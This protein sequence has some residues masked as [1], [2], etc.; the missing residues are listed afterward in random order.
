MNL[1]INYEKGGSERRRNEVSEIEARVMS[2]KMTIAF[3]LELVYSS[4]E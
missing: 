4:F 1:R 2:V 3:V